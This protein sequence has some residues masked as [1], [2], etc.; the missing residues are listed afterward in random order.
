MP[1][2]KM[3]ALIMIVSTMI[4]SG[5]QVDWSRMRETLGQAGLLARA[6]FANFIL[7]PAF[8]Y[9][10]VRHFN[11][12]TDVA[13][14]ILLMSMAPGVPFLVNSAGRN[15]GGSLVFA[16]EIAFLFSAL[17]L[18]TIP[19]TAT[20]LLPPAALAHAPAAKFLTTLVL[21]QIVPLLI[22]ALLAPRLSDSAATTLTKVLHLLFFAAL[23][24]LLV[25]VGPRLIQV[26]SA[27]YGAGHLLIIAAIGL[28]SAVVGWLLGGPDRQYRRTLSIATLMRNIGLCALI[29]ATSFPGTAVAPTVLTYLVITFIVSLPIRVFYARTREAISRPAL[30]REAHS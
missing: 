11:V 9:L 3:L 14:G 12:T 4:S 18:I 28:F 26:V 6:L 22:G 20:L 5:L 25:V 29:A 10:V 27:T 30:A 1:L 19:I 23:L 21:F 13:I 7:V 17:S 8:A 24:V 2:P 16:L 15:V